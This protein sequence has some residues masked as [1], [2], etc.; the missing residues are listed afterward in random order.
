MAHHIYTTPGFLI[1]SRP[2]GEAGKFF[3]VFTR[4]LGMIGARAQGVRLSQSKLRYHTQDYSFGYYSFVRG[5]DVWRMT[6]AQKIE[7]IMEVKKKN[8]RLYVQILTLL[9]RLLPGEEK[10]EHLFE[11]LEVFHTYLGHRDLE[12]EIGELVEC[13]TVLRIL[14]ALG[15]VKDQ[16]R[17]IVRGGEIRANI[18]EQVKESKERILKEIHDGLRHSQL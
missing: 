4:E 17:E 3:L 8:M 10:N 13:L 1:H 16:F 14:S 5:K 6:G 12:K 11:I 15:Y 2:S 7:G 9:K 18:L